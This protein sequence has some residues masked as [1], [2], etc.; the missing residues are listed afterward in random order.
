MA[1]SREL[2][3]GMDFGLSD[4]IGQIEGLVERLEAL[5]DQAENAEEAGR[6]V[7]SSIRAGADI[8]R[9]GVDD[10]TDSIREAASEA[11]DAGGSIGADFKQMGADADSFGRAVARS[12]GTA[13]KE[14]ESAAKGIQA[15]FQ[16]AIG[17]TEKK[18]VGLFGQF[19]KG[20]KE[21]GTAIT[22]PVKTI[23]DKLGGALL[24]AGKRTDDLGD[25]ADDAR[26]DLEDMGEAGSKAGGQIA[27]AI[28]GAFAAFVGIEAVKA[29]IEALKSFVGT[30]LE[31]AATAENTADK[32]NACFEGSDAADWVKNFGDTVH[33]S[34]AE[35]EG[36]MVSNKA[37]YGELGITGD[38]AAE[39]S[40]ITTSLAY[41]FGNAFSMADA[42]ALSLVQDAIK[43]NTAALEEYGIHIDEAALKNSAMELGL[44]SEID[45][46]NDAAM[47]QVR[48][49]A[50]LGQTESVQKAAITS[51]GG[52]ANSTK[53]LKG[54]WS[55]FVA[56]AGAKFTPTLEGL[57]GVIL[58]EWPTIEPM[59]LQFV[60]ILSN[61]MEQAAPILIELGQTLIPTL[62]S[63][64]GTL[65]EAGLPLL[66][67]FG[68]LAQTI[69]P[70]VAS[71]VG[72]I[73]G[74]VLPPLV[75]ILSTLNTS[76]IQ[77]LLPAVQKFAEA[78]L[79]PIAQLLNAISP[80][81]G[82]MSPVLSIIGDVLGI[83][84]EAL[85]K[86]VGWL[87]DGAGKVVSFFTGL[88][89]GARE[90]KKE[91]A[92]LGATIT[93]IGAAAEEIPPPDIDIDFPKPPKPEAPGVDPVT[94]PVIPDPVEIPNVGAD[95]EPVAIPT[96]LIPPIIPETAVDGVDI[97]VKVEPPAVPEPSI[98]PITVPVSVDPPTIP[99]PKVEAIDIPTRVEPPA[100]PEPSVEPV[101]IPTEV[102]PPVVPQ[103][104]MPSL[105]P[106]TLGA[107]DTTLFEK[108]IAQ[109]TAEAAQMVQEGTT[110]IRD[111]YTK[112]LNTIGTEA[113]R[114][115]AEMVV[116]AETAWKQMTSAADAGAEQIA[117]AFQRIA[118]AAREVG[119]AT[120]TVGANIPH[121]ANGT[122]NFEG[123]PTVMNEQGGEIAVLPKG[124]T[125][126]PADKSEQIINS[127]TT[128]T[129]ENRR[130]IKFSPNIHI[131]I[132][133][134]A[135][136]STVD[137]M[138]AELKTMFHELYQE[139]QEKDYAERAIQHGFT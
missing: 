129:T 37:M 81:L 26:K 43:G 78:L 116:A 89:G 35:I 62:T 103:P 80:V 59:L 113:A 135:D 125:I 77:P 25:S 126:I 4:A 97:P 45:T 9:A 124:S 17:F 74:T 24:A 40:K 88:F 48:M 16:G 41:D 102:F 83:V 68:E 6:E 65:F 101:E 105:D 7:G 67:V 27:D 20:F 72:M 2:T 32:F 134:S 44:G 10:L 14:G 5:T 115:H 76:I 64:L 54:V 110:K 109:A 91:I 13:L 46:L 121:N 69:L 84:A 11:D 61:G 73:A 23:K 85:G 127:V 108:S 128:S 136:N 93:E 130:E 53:S 51:T 139:E 112:E 34:K 31:A 49:N 66:S 90:S 132:E 98:E 28:K 99:K 12:M 95:V 106:I 92:D 71:I 36:F 58:D 100:I 47:A 39:L 114:A 96:T 122:D 1:D 55:D 57:M 50:I 33:R 133:G 104:E 56:D 22:H 118:E 120:I 70:P 52:L 138:V 107:A 75:D 19:K 29:G 30:A 38:A 94:F 42:D 15:G 63:V 3:F 86:V 137:H 131:T 8:G 123:G 87:V 21:M 82:A 111:T 18:A 60:D 79:P 119:G 117:G